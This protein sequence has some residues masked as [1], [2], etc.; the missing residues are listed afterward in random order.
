MPP[1]F[2]RNSFT[3]CQTIEAAPIHI[4]SLTRK[5]D[6]VC[7]TCVCVSTGHVH[8][9]FTFSSVLDMGSSTSSAQ[10]APPHAAS[11][12]HSSGLV[13]TP[14]AHLQKRGCP[15]IAGC[16]DAIAQRCAM[17]NARG[18]FRG[19]FRRK[20]SML[21]STNRQLQTPEVGATTTQAPHRSPV[22]LTKRLHACLA[23][24]AFVTSARRGRVFSLPGFACALQGGCTI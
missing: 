13:Q 19:G 17:G 7:F 11:Q 24:P 3:N 4:D 9:P 10:S 2:V 18:A 16:H 8:R 6:Q 22:S 21:P 15:F 1:D 20:G 23:M 12:V 5:R 14:F